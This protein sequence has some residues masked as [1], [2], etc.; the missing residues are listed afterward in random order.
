MGS[1]AGFRDQAADLAPCALGVLAELMS[2]DGQPGPVR[3]AAAKG[4][5]DYACKLSARS[6]DESLSKLDE[7]LEKMRSSC[8][9]MDE[10]QGS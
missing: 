1:M 4:V 7:L 9:V 3:V 10:D 6:Q 8:V 5:I 2:D